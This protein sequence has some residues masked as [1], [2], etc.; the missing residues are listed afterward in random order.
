MSNYIK[1]KNYDIA[2]GEGIG[3]SI[4]F[5][6]CDKPEKC[7]GCFNSEAWGFEVGKEFTDETINEI[8]ELLDKP[9]ISHLSIL[10]GEP[11]AVKNIDSAFKLAQE[12]KKI[13]PNKKIW[14]W[15]WRTFEDLLKSDYKIKV[16]GTDLY[17]NTIFNEIYSYHKILDY[18]DVLVDGPFIEEQKNLNL[19][20]RGSEN[21]RVINVKESLD[22]KETILFEN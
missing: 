2:N 13:L 21:Q 9:Y 11:F 6:G 5:S 10:G 12:V 1:I 8:I 7:K 4:F 17:N 16:L 20:W 14:I 19:K 15:T 3:V 22:K 18:V